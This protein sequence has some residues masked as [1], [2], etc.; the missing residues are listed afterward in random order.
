MKGKPAE[1]RKQ[2]P[3][4]PQ[5]KARGDKVKDGNLDHV[6]GGT[7]VADWTCLE[8]AATAM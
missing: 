1:R 7:L 5:D 8:N 3:K 2:G 4:E 6:T